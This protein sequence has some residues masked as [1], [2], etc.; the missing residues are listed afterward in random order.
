MKALLKVSAELEQ[1]SNFSR[2]L[3]ENYPGKNSFIVISWRLTKLPHL[4]I[5]FSGSFA[6]WSAIGT[7][8]QNDE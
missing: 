6:A 8:Q 1:Y 4:M 3:A 5:Q 7:L 2:V